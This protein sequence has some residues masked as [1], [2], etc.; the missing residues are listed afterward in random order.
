MTD[1]LLHIWR[2]NM[3]VNYNLVYTLCGKKTWKGDHEL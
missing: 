2:R 3:V 1:D